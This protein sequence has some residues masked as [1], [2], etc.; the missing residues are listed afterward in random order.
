MTWQDEENARRAARLHRERE[1]QD[2]HRRALPPGRAVT[3]LPPAPPRCNCGCQD[4]AAPYPAALG[5]IPPES[6]QPAAVLLAWQ[7]ARRDSDPLTASEEARA[8]WADRVAQADLAAGTV[9]LDGHE[10]LRRISVNRNPD[11]G[12]LSGSRA[13]ALIRQLEIGGVGHEPGCRP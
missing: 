11:G 12:R 5:D 2:A 6:D 1:W 7:L 3:R 8:L 13:L 9:P 4:A 10:A